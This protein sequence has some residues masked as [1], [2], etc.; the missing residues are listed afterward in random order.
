MQSE[1]EKLLELLGGVAETGILSSEAGERL[2]VSQHTA[3][4]RLNILV[5]SGK[6]RRVWVL[7]ENPWVVGGTWTRPGYAIVDEKE[8]TSE[9]GE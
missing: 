1:D 8:G 6:A 9:G 5:K 3:R 2:G 4:R 7:R